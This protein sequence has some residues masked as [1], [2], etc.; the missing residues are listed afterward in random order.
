MKKKKYKVVKKKKIENKLNG[1]KQQ[2][3]DFVQ[4]ESKLEIK[5]KLMN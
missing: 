1:P 4:N 3:K 5:Y 2:Q